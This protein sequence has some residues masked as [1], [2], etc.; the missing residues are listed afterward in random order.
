MAG[1][2]STTITVPCRPRSCTCTRH[3]RPPRFPSSPTSD[4]CHEVGAPAG[5][6]R[7]SE[8]PSVDGEAA[9][10]AEAQ[11]EA[12][13]VVPRPRSP[14]HPPGWS[15][16]V[17]VVVRF[18]R[19]D[20]HRSLRRRVRVHETDLQGLRPPLRHGASRAPI[21]LL[22]GR[23][24]AWPCRTRTGTT[25][26]SLDLGHT[27]R[28]QRLVVTRGG[29]YL[30]YRPPP[31]GIPSTV[32]PGSPRGRRLGSPESRRAPGIRSPPPPRAP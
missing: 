5:H 2:S 1:N 27:R 11:A 6:L 21:R 29:R 32:L 8:L 10:P 18:Q 25:E 13:S 7:T 17:V 22:P 3:G 16:P 12:R 14:L 30:K 31:G 20:G 26:S 9:L 19:V 15:R 28:I 24:P 4:P 23:L